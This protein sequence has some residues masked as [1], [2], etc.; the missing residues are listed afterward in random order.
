[1]NHLKSIF[2]LYAEA[3]NMQAI[4]DASNAR[5]NVPFWSTWFR[6][7]L[8]QQSLTY[9]TAIG[10]SRLDAAA[11]LVSRDGRTPLRSRGSIG[12]LTGEI[13][14]IKVMKTL[15]EEDYRSFLMFQALQ[16]ADATKKAQLLGFMF[17]DIAS[18]INSVNR[19]IDYMVAEGMSTGK[20]TITADNNPDGIV[21][22]DIDL[23]M[24]ADNFRT[25]VDNWS[26]NPDADI[27]KDIRNVMLAVKAAGKTGITRMVIDDAL[28][29]IVANNNSLASYLKGYYNPGSN[30]TYV[31]T[32]DTVNTMLKANRLPVFEIIEV[33]IP[34]EVDGRNVNSYPWKKENVLFCGDGYLGEIKNALAIEQ[35]QP[36]PQVSYST[37]N[38]GILVSK[39]FANEPF[40]EYTKAEWN[41]F[42]SFDQ[43]DNMFLLQTDME[44]V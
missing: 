23:L 9:V 44:T 35:L 25:V 19:K 34:I 32:L 40:G 24:P 13:P 39:W 27:V 42:P 17:G 10:K 37:G 38:A 33:M 5:F 43:I 16:I 4:I 21:M 7:G 18:V 15:N 36:V 2:G 29:Q 14:A 20:I 28:W 12:K 3:A 1:M 41:A 31:L 26:T 30:N 8:P 11:S 22:D 6:A